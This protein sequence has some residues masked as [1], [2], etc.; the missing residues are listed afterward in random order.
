MNVNIQLFRY[1]II[2]L[3]IISLTLKTSRSFT[4]E[5]FPQFNSAYYE[6]LPVAN[7]PR[8]GENSG[9]KLD[10]LRQLC[11]ERN[12]VGKLGRYLIYKK[13]I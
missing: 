3:H 9:K 1:T 11:F 7:K 6:Y 13:P 2:Y 10:F 12:L 8:S 4:L 5:C